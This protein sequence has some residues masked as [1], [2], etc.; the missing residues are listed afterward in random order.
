MKS[1][2]VFSFKFLK[3]FAITLTLFAINAGEAQ[4]NSIRLAVV[5]FFAPPGNGDIQQ[6]AAIAPDLLM[7][8][9][10]HDNRFQLVEREKINAIWS[11]L[12]L[13]E[14]GLTSADT[15]GKLGRIL[16]C[17]WLVSGSFVQTESGIQVWVK[18]IETQNSVVLDLQA[19]TYNPTNFSETVSNVA[20]FLTQVSPHS[21]PHQFVSLENFV[22]ISASSARE[23]WSQ[24][25]SALIEKHFLAA[26]FGVVER[27]TVSPIFSEY[28]LQ[29]A[30]LI[31]DSTNRVKLKPAFWI[32][33]GTCKWVH[34]T[35]DELSVELRIR[36]TQGGE[37]F[38]RFTKPP[39][40]ELEK[41]I[42][43]SIQS[44]LTNSSPMTL[45]QTETAEA[46][47]RT[48]HIQELG[49]GRGELPISSRYNTNTT[50]II[51]TDPY[52]GKRQMTVDPAWQARVENHK[53][54]MFNTLEQAILLN[55]GDMFS[56]LTLG[57]AL[58]KNDD[59]VESKRGEDLLEEVAASGDAVNAT[60]A[61]NWLEDFRTG[62]LAFARNLAGQVE[63]VI[64]GQ[65][66]SIPAYTNPPP[67]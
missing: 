52:G 28:Q 29:T 53:R 57:K 20:A 34:D 39:G 51:V 56:K 10:S 66:A 16:S 11:E 58:F 21:S 63:I 62:R 1:R 9:L 15:V 18:V 54:D 4:T 36:K 59:S 65:P 12:H 44:V 46:N 5:P 31:G 7:V 49:K 38:F 13:A 26:G 61:K 8:E 35:Q 43:D 37:N 33:D 41:A 14:A 42:V 25:L 6:I 19:V 17:D 45:E 22:D 55:P 48:A 67:P 50:S 40:D 64:H 30:G 60:K 2:K 24:R 23:D 27:E 3:L 32:V 47:I